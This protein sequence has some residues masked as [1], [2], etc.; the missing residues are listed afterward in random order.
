M[1]VLFIAGFGPISRE[2]GPARSFYL[3]ALGLHL[4]SDGDYLHTGDLPGARH[5]AVWPLADAA[6]S[7]FGREAWPEDLP[8]PQAWLEFDVEDI[9]GATRELEQR[10]YRLLVADREEPWGQRVTR[11]IGPEGLLVGVTHTPW[12]REGPQG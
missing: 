7:C 9:A 5:F 12:L 11:L 10:G 4:E 8:V 3:D 2:S 6:R 1:Q